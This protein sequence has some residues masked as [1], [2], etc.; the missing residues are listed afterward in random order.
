MRDIDSFG[1]MPRRRKTKVRTVIM[2]WTDNK[3]TCG[4]CGHEVR[5]LEVKHGWVVAEPDNVQE[6]ETQ[7]DDKRHRKH[8]CPP[9]QTFTLED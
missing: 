4:G 3:R 5:K 9:R 1:S 2:A 8:Y 6:G 7:F